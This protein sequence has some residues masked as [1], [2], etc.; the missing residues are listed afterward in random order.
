M[1]GLPFNTTGERLLICTSKTEW[2]TIVTNH[3]IKRSFNDEQ[4]LIYSDRCTIVRWYNQIRQLNKGTTRSLTR[5]G[6]RLHSWIVEY[7]DISSL[8]ANIT[9]TTINQR[10]SNS[11]GTSVIRPSKRVR[12][13]NNIIVQTVRWTS[14][15][16]LFSD[17]MKGSFNMIFNRAWKP[18]T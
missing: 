17:L 8:I 3:S 4:G 1:K 11:R 9:L 16:Q 13:Y 15:K 5:I 10:S 12:T 2:S 18:F 6:E 14:M 7:N